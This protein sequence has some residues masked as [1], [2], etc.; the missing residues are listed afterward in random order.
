M[1]P[2]NGGLAGS[3]S[4]PILPRSRSDFKENGATPSPKH[5]KLTESDGLT[6]AGYTD[7][8]D[9]VLGRS[10]G[11][12]GI[13]VKM[14]DKKHALEDMVGWSEN[15][16][17][18]QYDAQQ[19]QNFLDYME[20]R[21][22]VELIELINSLDRKGEIFLEVRKKGSL[23]AFNKVLKESKKQD[24]ALDVHLHEI[25]RD[26]IGC[27]LI[28][29]D[30]STLVST[31]KALLQSEQI[32]ISTDG[33]ELY[34]AP[35]RRY[36]NKSSRYQRLVER[37]GL[38]K[39]QAK[40]TDEVKLTNYE[41]LHCYISFTHPDKFIKTKIDNLIP[42]IE[43]NRQ[44]RYR[45]E[46][47]RIAELYEYMSQSYRSLIIEFPIECQMRTMLEHLWAS[48]EHKYVYEKIKSGSITDD[49]SSVSILRG[50]FT[51]L[52]Y[53][54][55]SIDD[56][57]DIV[58]N[59]S[60]NYQDKG[61]PFYSG[62]SKDISEIRTR[63]FKEGDRSLNLIRDSAILY[64]EMQLNVGSKGDLAD[65]LRPIYEKLYEAH[66]QLRDEK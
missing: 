60:S 32:E 19:A 7:K 36:E 33:F 66:R 65:S 17:T 8:N 24:K 42:G 5:L 45:A 2:G 23:S 48:E 34:S 40:P 54:Y 11:R 59:V 49:N 35:F 61:K 26:F 63:Y 53:H 25:V 46:A 43:A 44:T 21:I 56:I 9:G 30:E 57:R 41:S 50:A 27:R 22:R 47:E 55:N 51:A 16:F 18:S 12:F 39:N 31:F 38:S 20:N 62:S 10:Q 52:K 64:Q 58:R 6:K 13:F 29:V 3:S 15:D 28:C 37:L 4:N 1:H 14:F